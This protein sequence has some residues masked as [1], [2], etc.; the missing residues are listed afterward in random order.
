MMTNPTGEM[1]VKA[2][3]K[4][5]RLHLGMSVLADLQEQFGER[6]D[7]V[8]SPPKKGDKLP[9]LKVMHAVF[10]GALQRYHGEEADRWLV[11]DIIEQNENAWGKLLTASAPDPLEGDK[12]RG[13]RKAA[14]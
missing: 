7:A 4:T 11:D 14:A 10:L 6:L 2:R 1:T 9:D 12:P 8:L 5:Y 3:G 13:K